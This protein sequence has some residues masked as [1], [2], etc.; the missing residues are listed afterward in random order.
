MTSTTPR[1]PASSNTGSQASLLYLGMFGAV[2]QGIMAAVKPNFA[3]RFS[4]DRVL[5][6]FRTGSTPQRMKVSRWP[7]SS[8]LFQS[9]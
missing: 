9:L 5:L 8:L 2:T 3:S 6:K 4:S 1:S 7:P